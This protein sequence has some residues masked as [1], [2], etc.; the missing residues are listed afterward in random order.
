MCA[1][2]M[3]YFVF[4]RIYTIT[5]VPLRHAYNLKKATYG[6]WATVLVYRAYLHTQLELKQERE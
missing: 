4:R 3:E 1:E 2:K 5:Q 6:L